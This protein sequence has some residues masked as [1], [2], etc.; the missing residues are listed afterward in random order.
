MKGFSLEEEE[1]EVVNHG[2]AYQGKRTILWEPA[3]VSLWLVA[4]QGCKVLS[5]HF[6]KAG[7][8]SRPNWNIVM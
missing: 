4:E 3:L 5:V 6:N 8:M 2:N 1:E 7:L